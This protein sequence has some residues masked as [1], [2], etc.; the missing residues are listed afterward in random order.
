MTASPSGST[1]FAS[2]G[3]GDC[4]SWRVPISSPEQL[5]ASLSAAF[6]LMGYVHKEQRLVEFP[7]ISTDGSEERIATLMPYYMN[8]NDPSAVGVWGVRLEGQ[9][10]IRITV[11]PDGKGIPS[12]TLTQ[13]GINNGIEYFLTLNPEEADVYV[14]SLLRCAQS[15]EFKAAQMQVS[16]PERPMGWLKRLFGLVK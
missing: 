13:K 11:T 8:K 4:L 3:T 10:D 9:N 16:K 12:F 14:R 1:E 15:D 5:Q 6:P 2:S 7:I